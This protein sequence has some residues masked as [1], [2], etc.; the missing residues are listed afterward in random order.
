MLNQVALIGRLT[1]DIDLRRTQAGKEVGQ[2]TLAVNRNY[3]NAQGNVDAD[4]ITCQIWRNADV[5]SKYTHKGS[6]ISITGQIQTGSYDNKQ[7]QRVYT[8]D[9]VVDHFD[10]L[11][12]KSSSAHSRQNNTANPSVNNGQPIDISD[13]LPF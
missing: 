11:E 10:F 2:F 13:D 6:L 12:S 3:K 4:F 8:T 1:R 5:L 9:V 7:G